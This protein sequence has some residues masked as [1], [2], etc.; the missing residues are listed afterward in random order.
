M[1]SR[2]F[3]LTALGVFGIGWSKNGLS[4]LILPEDHE[5]GVG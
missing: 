4:R 2:H 5:A 3:F 1:R